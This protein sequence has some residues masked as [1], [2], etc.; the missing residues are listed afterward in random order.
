M[1]AAIKHLSYFRC[2]NVHLDRES[3]SMLHNNG[4]DHSLSHMPQLTW[5]C[6]RSYNVIS[7]QLPKIAVSK[8]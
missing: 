8:K 4:S 6:D 5:A 7:L 2:L 1:I 3:D